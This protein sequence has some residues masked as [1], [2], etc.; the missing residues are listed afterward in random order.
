MKLTKL[1]KNTVVA[2]G[3]DSQF[4]YKWLGILASVEE[5]VFSDETV[6]MIL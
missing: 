2:K 1:Y 3:F 6:K 4:N 5:V